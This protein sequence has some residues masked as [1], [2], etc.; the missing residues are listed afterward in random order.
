MPGVTSNGSSPCTHAISELLDSFGGYPKLK[1]LDEYV[2]RAVWSD[3]CR[4]LDR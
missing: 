3:V 1:D 2:T 4:D